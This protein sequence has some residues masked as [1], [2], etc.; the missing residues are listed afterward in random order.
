MANSCLSPLLSTS[1]QIW[2]CIF[3]GADPLLGFA[4]HFAFFAEA[5]NRRKRLVTRKSALEMRLS[6]KSALEMLLSWH[7]RAAK[8]PFLSH[9]GLEICPRNC[10]SDPPTDP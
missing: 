8:M 4:R 6:C 5:V 3:A 2:A 9:I 10:Q 1:W 7:L